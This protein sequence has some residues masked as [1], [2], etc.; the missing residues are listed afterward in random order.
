MLSKLGKILQFLSEYTQDLWLCLK[1]NGYSPFVDRQKRLFYK[2]IIETHTIEKGLS[3][4]RRRPLFGRDKIRFVM[5]A[6]DTYPPSFSP[7]PVQMV[8]GALNAYVQFHRDQNVDDPLLNDIDNFLGRW[9][10]K[11]SLAIHGGI[12]SFQFDACHHEDPAALLKSRSSLRMFDGSKLPVEEIC[13]LV[14]LAQSAPS[15]CNRQSTQIHLYQD[16]HTIDTLLALQGGSRG[17]SE[18][19]AN[20]FIVGSEVAAWGGPGQRNQPYVD[21]A[22]FAMSLLL[23]CHSRG[24]GACPLNLAVTNAKE[25]EI[26]NV[27]KIPAGERLIMMIAFGKTVAEPLR[28]AVSPRRDLN[29]VLHL[30]GEIASQ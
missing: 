3:L 23:A 21:G 8:L 2:I 6:L 28:V 7:L 4:P 17:F 12:K 29:E 5:A 11:S 22:L 18:H 26:K 24:L 13:R 27:A 14:A 15:Q 30:H 9:H 25:R 10:G 19:V 16:R 1:Y 20:L